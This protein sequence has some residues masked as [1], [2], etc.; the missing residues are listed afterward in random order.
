MNKIGR[1]LFL[2]K[3]GAVT[4][5]AIVVPTII[6]ACA[7]G[8][9]GHKAPSDRINL[10]F[11]GAGNMGC[12]DVRNFLSDSRVQ[13]TAACDVNRQSEYQDGRLGGRD[14]MKWMVNKEYSEQSGKKYR[15]CKAYTDFREV[16]LKKDIDAVEVITPDHWHSIPVLMAAAAGKDIFCQK[17]LSLTIPEGRA[18]SNAASKFNVVFQTGSQRRSDDHFRRICEIVRNGR[19]G[20]LGT[21]RVGLPSGTPDY[22]KTGHLTDTIAVPKGLDYNT[23]LGPA[24]EEPYCPARTLVNYRWILDYSGGQLTDWGGHFIDMAQWGMGTDNTGPVRVK[25][26]KARWSDHPVYNT[27]TEFYFECVYENG[28]KLI[29]STDEEFGIKFEGSEGSIGRDSANPESLLDTIIGP[30]EIQLYRSNG[31]HH[32]NFIDCVIS[33][34]ETSA[35]AEIGHRSI[36][37]SHLGNIAMILGRDLDWDP[38][39]EQ[40]LND[41]QA[42]LML[43][44]EMREPW[45]SIYKKYAV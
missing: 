3:Y 23:W 10:A 32:K 25:N 7:R 35:P 20:E 26:A 8:K 33:R 28:V 36:T 29:V 15:S 19:I 4:A 12:I 5:G 6:P 18:M 30:D 31:G 41:E 42:N 13:V 16:L 24:P 2:K 11:I 39:K 1:R 37:I 43:S 38:V 40:F 17:P 14:F 34:K 44:R 27:A 9:D 45:A 21:V 22:A